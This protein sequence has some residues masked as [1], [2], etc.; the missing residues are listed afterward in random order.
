MDEGFLHVNV[1][2]FFTHFVMM[3]ESD[4]MRER[5]YEEMK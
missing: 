3:L 1:S 2:L 4:G 5:G